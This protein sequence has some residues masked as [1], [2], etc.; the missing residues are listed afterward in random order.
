MSSKRYVDAHCHL[1]DDRFSQPQQN[2]LIQQAQT[3][4]IEF[5]MQGG[6]NPADWEKQIELAKK[7]KGQIGLCFGLHPYFVAQSTEE[8]CETALDHLSHS[9]HLAHAVGETGLDFRTQYCADDKAE[10]KQLEYFEAQVEL[11]QVA[12]KPLVLHIVRAHEPATRALSVWDLPSP[13]GKFSG[14]VHAFNSSYEVALQY[15]DL[16]FM[17]SIGGALTHP[18]N[19][20]LR[21]CVQK[22]PKECLLIESD[23]PDQRPLNWGHDLNQSSSIFD[24]AQVM[25]ELRGDLSQFEMLTQSAE[26]FKRLFPAISG[27]TF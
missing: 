16:G 11:A 20:D 22:L 12:A 3:L 6:V 26:N 27:A 21:A 19:R 2:E 4:G 14:M 15:L 17:L 1:V 24:V 10:A 5:F 23:S 18:R 13:V 9:L 25:S 7:F 8:E